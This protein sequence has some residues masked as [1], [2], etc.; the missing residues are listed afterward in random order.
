MLAEEENKLAASCGAQGQRRVVREKKH[1]GW[2]DLLLAAYRGRKGAVSM[3]LGEKADP[4]ETD[5]LGRTALIHAAAQGH[6]K[7]VEVLIEAGTDVLYSP[8]TDGRT[9]LHWSA[10]YGHRQCCDLL[11]NA[12]GNVAEFDNDG[13][14]PQVLAVLG[15]ANFLL[16]TTADSLSID[17]VNQKVE[18]EEKEHEDERAATEAAAEEANAAEK[19]ERRKE[20]ARQ[21]KEKHEQ[22]EREQ[23]AQN[24][25][26]E[27]ETQEAAK[28]GDSPLKKGQSKPGARHSSTTGGSASLKTPSSRNSTATPLPKT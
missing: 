1:E 18:E 14:S 12:G 17:Q 6:E 8:S 9:A 7:V 15:G 11:Q 2:S 13:H 25:K 22:A 3:L 19:E 4:N 24:Q 27:L 20:A 26:K 28:G 5:N 16:F 23:K 21:H 10:F